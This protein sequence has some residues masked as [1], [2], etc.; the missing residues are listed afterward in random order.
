[1]LERTN[2]RKYLATHPWISFSVDLTRANPKLWMRLGECVSKCEHLARMP[3]RPAVAQQLHLLYLAKGARAT[4]AIEGNTL[5]EEEVRRLISDETRV[6]APNEYLEHEVANVVRL[7]N[8]IEDTVAKR[9]SI[10]ISIDRLKYINRVVLTGLECPEHVRPGEITTT[11]LV[12]GRYRAAPPEDCDYL[13]SRL[14]EWLNSSQF[15]TESKKSEEVIPLSIIRAILAHLYIA[16]IHPFGD[17]NG[18]TARLG[19]YQILLTSGVPGP[20]S[21][22]FTNHYN[23]TRSEYY[24]RL[25]QASKSPEGVIEFL[26][27]AV[28][29]FCQGLREQL[30]YIWEQN[31]DVV[32][33]SYVY[34][35]FKEVDR[36]TSGR[37]Q[38]D[39][40]LDLSRKKEPVPLREIPN[41]TPR[42]AS[43]YARKTDKTLIRDLKIVEKMKLVERTSAGYIA[44]KAAILAYLP[45]QSQHGTPTS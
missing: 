14:C 30:E 40:V 37:R 23:E 31:Y 26:Q 38:R 7:F 34:A 32:W 10:D 16:W 1:M 43:A 27:Y 17:G 44:N 28:D 11:Q 24:R 2:N 29:G 33:R 35:Q 3:L 42:L 9:E 19:E 8:E 22:L 18:R 15:V 20:A 12:V 36:K 39:L 6:T 4:V 21:H 25:D 45:T 13:L 41:L 5:T